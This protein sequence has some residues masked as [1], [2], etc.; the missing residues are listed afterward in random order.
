MN[1]KKILS[2]LI[3]SVLVIGGFTVIAGH[4]RAQEEEEGQLINEVHFDV[5]LDMEDGVVATYEG[6]TH[7][8]MHGVDGVRYN[9]L[10]E[11]WRIQLDTWSVL[12]SYNNLLLNPAYEGSGTPEMEEA[13]DEGWVDEPEDVRWLANN[14]DGDWTVNPFAHEDIRFALQ[15]LNREAIIEDLLDGFG[16]PR[17]GFMREGI[18]A[19]QEHYVPGIQEQFDI[20]EEGDEDYMEEWIEAA[21]EEIQEEAA[22]GEVTGNMDEGWYYEHAE[23]GTDQHQIEII[24]MARSEDWR[25]E[26][27]D[28]MEEVLEGVGFD[29]TVDPTP[30]GEAIP[31]A[32]FGD[33]EPYDNLDYHIYTGGWVS[34]QTVAYQHAACSQM[35]APWYGFMQ[36]YSPSEHWNYDEEDYDRPIAAHEDGSGWDPGYTVGDMDAEAQALHVGQGME[37]EDDYWEQQVKVTQLGFTESL[38]IFLTTGQDFYPYNPERMLSAVPEGTNGYDTYFGPRTMRTDNAQLETEILTGEDQPYMDNWNFYGGSADV[39]GEYQRRMLREWNSWPHPED[40]L[41]MQVNAYWMDN[42]ELEQHRPERNHPYDIQGEVVTDFEF[43]EGELIENI[44]IP[45]E[46]AVDYIPGYVEDIEVEWDDEE[47]MWVVEEE[48]PAE[49]Q[50]MTAEDMAE[51]EEATLTDNETLLED[52]DAEEEDLIEYVPLNPGVMDG[53][54]AVQVTIDIHEEH[55]WHDGT[56][57]DLQDVMADYARSKELGDDTFA[58]YLASHDALNSVFWNAIHAMEWNEEDG[59][60]TVWGDYTFPVEDLLGYFYAMS[61]ETHP[62]TYEGWNHLHGGDATEFGDDDEMPYDYEPVE[63]FDWIHQISSVHSADLAT[64]LE[65]MRD[66]EWIPY[67]LRED[68]GSPMPMDEDELTTQLDSVIDFIDEYEHSY[69]GKGPFMLE[70]YDEDDH[71][72]ELVRWDGYGFPFEGEEAG[73]ETFEYGYW[74][75]Q[76]EIEGVRL[77]TVDLEEDELV[78]G[79]EIEATGTG[80]WAELFPSPG[81]RALTEDDLEDYRFVLVDPDTLEEI[82]VIPRDEVELIEADGFSTFEGTIPTEDVEEGGTYEVQLQAR[83]EPPIYEVAIAAVTLFEG[84]WDIEITAPEDGDEFEEGDEVTL[85]YTVTADYEDTQDIVFEVDGE[86]I[87]TEELTLE[88]GET[89]DG[90]FTWDA[91]EEGDYELTVSTDDEEDSISI[92]VV[93]EVVEEVPGFT[94]GLLVLGAIVAVAIYYKKKQ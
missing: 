58:P 21:M 5:V 50:W 31:R 92:S 7:L 62:L 90:E 25:Q 36:T 46:D 6:D 41:P 94:L 80:V 33:P 35:Y 78:I 49:R 71:T 45:M 39:Y 42:E 8:F 52:P 86:E 82:T 89:Y 85:E 63:G 67:Y 76:F 60:Y 34:T 64:V 55:V 73:G 29:V 10:D 75:E 65:D 18:P 3:V 19:W 9:E 2:L 84:V 27:G 32:F 38:R 22:F 77:D 59:T 12:G 16:V 23:S 14:V 54:A 72:M 87:E 70:D 57:Y 56:D 43:E 40:G 13:V 61:Q 15:Y 69:I 79:E 83:E 17:Y 20:W 91:E 47:E 88:A 28:Y 74:A 30:S 68:R 44:D 66:E 48:I 24:I 4:T 37:V 26:L 81:E 11:E 51:A 93:E 53:Q 1:W